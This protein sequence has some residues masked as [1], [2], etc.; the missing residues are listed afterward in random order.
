MI[1]ANGELIGYGGNFGRSRIRSRAIR[2]LGIIRQRVTGKDRGDLRIDGNHQRVAGKSS[3]IQ[4]LALAGSRHG[5]HLRGSEHL[6]EALILAEIVGLSA[7]IV[8]ARQKHRTGRRLEA[9]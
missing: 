2:S 9:G 4:P 6:P 8:E 1:D 7:P 3:C 5:K